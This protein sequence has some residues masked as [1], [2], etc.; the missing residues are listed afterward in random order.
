MNKVTVIGKYLFAIP[1]IIFGALNLFN[2]SMSTDLEPIPGGVVWVAVAG[3]T[4][5]LSG[6]AIIIGRKDGVATFLL[7]L[8]LLVFALLV[9][10]PDVM[11]TPGND[12]DL[13]ATTNLLKD[14]ALAGASF[15]YSRSAAH[16]RTT[17]LT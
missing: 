4:M 2:A 11:D 6:V 8:V 14:L 16:D 3:L 5:L 12:V 17:R 15:V 10:L 1:F 7:G 13:I 9:H